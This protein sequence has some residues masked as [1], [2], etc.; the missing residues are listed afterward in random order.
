ML[1][2]PLRWLQVEEGPVLWVSAQNPWTQKACKTRCVD[3]RP[4]GRCVMDE[5]ATLG[6]RAAG[7]R[8]LDWR[9]GVAAGERWGVTDMTSGEDDRLSKLSESRDRAITTVGKGVGQEQ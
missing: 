5:C 2:L 6:R 3:L 9:C 7:S 4:R 8:S 1:S